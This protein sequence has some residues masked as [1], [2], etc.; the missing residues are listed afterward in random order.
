MKNTLSSEN[1]SFSILMVNHNNEDNI[2]ETIQSV[3]DTNLL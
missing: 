1:I 2:E 3:I